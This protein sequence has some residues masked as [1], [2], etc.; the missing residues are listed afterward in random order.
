ML[1]NT[2]R[3]RSLAN[4]SLLSTVPCA[5]PRQAKRGEVSLQRLGS[6]TLLQ[7][8]QRGAEWAE[9]NSVKW[10][11]GRE[12]AAR[13]CRWG[14]GRRWEG[15]QRIQ[16]LR[17]TSPQVRKERLKWQQPGATVHNH[18]R[19]KGSLSLPNLL[20]W[21]LIMTCMKSNIQRRQ[22]IINTR[23]L[24]LRSSSQHSYSLANRK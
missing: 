21:W 12:D 20:G 15:V 8:G 23:K 16:K 14:A 3:Y 22:M 7:A 13:C 24:S 4:I 11:E 6:S 10:R 5:D 9:V 18:Q 19:V 2:E 17:A 1:E